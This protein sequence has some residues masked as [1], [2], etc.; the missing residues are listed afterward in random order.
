LRTMK[1]EGAELIGE[2]VS[3][4]GAVAAAD[5]EHLAVAYA[6]GALLAIDTPLRVTGLDWLDRAAAIAARITD[7]VNPIMPLL[8]PLAALFGTLN[9]GRSPVGPEIFDDAAGDPHPWVAAI[10]RILR[11]HWALNLGRRHAQAEADFL[12]G[13]KILAELGERWGQAIALGGLAMLEGWRGEH[14]AA[15][16]HYRRATELTAAFGSTEDEVQF[17]LFIVRQLWLAGEREAARAELAR[18]LPDVERIG[19]PEIQ[20][21]AVYTVGDLARL[22]G[23]PEAAREAFVRVMQMAASA[24]V[25]QQVGAVAATGLGYLAGAEGDLDAARDWHAQAIAAARFTADAPVLAEA[26]AGLADLTLREGDPER[27]AELLGASFA[28]RGTTDRSVPDEER[29][30][31]AAR[32]VLG[33]ARYGAAYQRGQCVTVD[34]LAALIPVTPV[35]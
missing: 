7:P 24:G 20:A 19:L 13:A 3:V 6:M 31:A 35:A 1:V 4:P 11:G 23:R 8:G 27:A 29:V 26:V 34:T 17:R 10:A 33:D 28:I 2:A 32:S 5:P 18:A 16:G 30:A 9:P 14:A 12:A 25:A 22:D 15:V 21:Y